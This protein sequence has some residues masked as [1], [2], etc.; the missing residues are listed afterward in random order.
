M[1]RIAMIEPDHYCDCV[2]P[3]PVE[4]SA[5]ITPSSSQRYTVTEQLVEPDE[6]RD[7]VTIDSVRVSVCHRDRISLES[8]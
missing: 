7:L 1:I 8:T 6:S 4:S 3:F 2:S 5:P